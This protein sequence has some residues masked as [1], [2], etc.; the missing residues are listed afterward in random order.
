[1]PRYA[2]AQNDMRQVPS[3]QNFVNPTPAIQSIQPV[4][5][6]MNI[7][8]SH[9]SHNGNT[10][11]I[12][13]NAHTSH[14]GRTNQNS[15]NGYIS[16]NVRSGHTSDNV[17]NGHT[18]DNSRNG[19]TSDNLRVGHT[20]HNHRDPRRGLNGHSRHTSNTM[21]KVKNENISPRIPTATG[22]N[23]LI[24]KLVPKPS[25]INQ[26]ANAKKYSDSLRKASKLD[27]EISSIS[28]HSDLMNLRSKGM[29]N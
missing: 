16:D 14:N 5:V 23:K 9:T 26:N 2:H 28:T 1:M 11:Q 8:T 29:H 19:H 4:K 7:N 6:P 10:N 3:I 22:Y 15:N 20:S 24:S 17:R 25:K 21:L 27:D 12:G 18:S 13:K